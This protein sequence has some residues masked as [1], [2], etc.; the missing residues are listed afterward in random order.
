MQGS[1][2][3]AERYRVAEGGTPPYPQGPNVGV[4][5]QPSCVERA[6]DVTSSAGCM[7]QRMINGNLMLLRLVNS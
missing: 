4:A 2:A 1:I 5:T 6:G 3:A 7:S